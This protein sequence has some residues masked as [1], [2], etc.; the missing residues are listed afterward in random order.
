MEDF[1]LTQEWIGYSNKRDQLKLPFNVLMKGSYNTLINDTEKVVIRPGFSIFGAVKTGNVG[2]KT[3]YDW[4]TNTLVERNLRCFSGKLQV[5]Y[6]GTWID[7]ITGFPKTAFQ[8][9]EWWDTGE[10]LDRLL[11]VNGD[12]N[13]YDWAGGITE[14]ASVT[15]NTITKKWI[16]TGTTYS[17][18]ARADSETNAYIT[19]SGSGFVTAGFT[20]GDYVVVSGSTSNDGTYL[21]SGVTA[22]TLTLALI[23]NLTTEGAG[24]TVTINKE[25]VGTWGEQRFVTTGTR[26]VTIGNT[27][28][29][30]TG[31]EGTGTLT[32]VTPDPSSGGVVAGDIAIQ[33]VKTTQNSPASG[34]VNDLIAML[35]NQIYVGSL[36]SREVYVSSNTDYTDFTFTSPVRVPGEGALLTLDQACVAFVVKDKDMYIYAGK[37]LAYKTV[38][39]LTS[40]G[41]NETLT[42]E[43]LKTGADQ[44]PQSQNMV[45]YIKNNIVYITNEPTLDSIGRIEN[46]D[47]EQSKPLS[48][49]V[50][51]DFDVY[52]FTDAH[53]KY[54]KNAIYIT[55]PREGLY[56]IYDLEYRYWQ[57]PQRANISCWSII[58]G[59]L[60]G[61]SSVGDETYRMFFDIVDGEK[62]FYTD[63]NGSAITWAMVHAYQ[64]LGNHGEMY[65]F[66]SYFSMYYIKSGADVLMTLDYELYGSARQSEYILNGS[67]ESSQE[68]NTF[69]TNQD[70]GMGQ[71]PL[72]Q[73]PNAGSVEEERPLI[74]KRT[75]KQMTAT[76]F[77][78]FRVTYSGEGLNDRFELL[79]HGSNAQLSQTDPGY[80]KE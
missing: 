9:A 27:E 31:G 6:E 80:L 67:S 28:Y 75:I 18:T 62:V 24:D 43:R 55:L 60:Y 34:V 19:D 57:P 23:E 2:I 66:D 22:S 37:S 29:T 52:D 20:A 11:F 46:I 69:D 72:G 8:F 14:V 73:Q 71:Y 3:S 30:Y 58:D 21:V 78:N 35:D 77:F 70:P 17:F 12:D 61:H 53:I 59:H 38:F 79:A 10:S 45:G 74:L 5:N 41:Q 32:G 40:D 36:R 49:N 33:T 26:K 42:I 7:V 56:L 13:I 63:D 25:N 54:W 47:T 15:S 48:D 68:D 1:L 64:N 65:N 51:N 4:I 76:D 16:V 44:A 39:E 50:K